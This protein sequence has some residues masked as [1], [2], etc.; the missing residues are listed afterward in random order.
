[1]SDMVDGEVL[2]FSSAYPIQV[3]VRPTGGDLLSWKE[4]DLGPG[5]FRIEPGTEVGVR[6]HST[7][8]ETLREIVQEFQACKS[9]SHLDLSENRKISDT[10]I[11][12][13]LHL[14][15]LRELNLSS[16]D[17]TNDVFSTL[18]V[19]SGLEILNLSFC[20]RISDIGLKSIR[21]LKNLVY[22]DLQGCPRITR[23]GLAWIERAGLTIHKH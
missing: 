13:L 19:F 14:N 23:A 22:L 21:D 4:L 17:I 5:Y 6:I 20:P 10:G 16:C 8:D 1:M 7:N 2:S 9:L 12:Y 11:E 3:L 18:K 15:S